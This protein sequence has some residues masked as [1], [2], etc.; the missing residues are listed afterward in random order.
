MTKNDVYEQ[1]SSSIS[2]ICDKHGLRFDGLHIFEEQHLSRLR[3]SIS[4]SEQ[5][6]QDHI[7]LM[8]FLKLSG[9][10]IENTKISPTEIRSEDNAIAIRVNFDNINYPIVIMRDNVVECI[11]LQEFKYIFSISE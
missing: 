5:R 7:L 8:D 3:F 6:K 1:I 10:N 2:E 11:S 9:I 4:D